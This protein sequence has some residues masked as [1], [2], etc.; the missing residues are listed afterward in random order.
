M[1]DYDIR[2]FFINQFFER[3]MLRSVVEID[4]K[5]IV[6]SSG[7]WVKF[8]RTHYQRVESHLIKLLAKDLN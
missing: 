7:C 5:A 1:N 3:H 2:A 8:A 6:D 4:R